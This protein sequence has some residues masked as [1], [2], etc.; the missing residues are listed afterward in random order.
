MNGKLVITG[1]IVDN[2][3]IISTLIDKG[4]Q[5]YAAMSEALFKKPGL[6]YIADGKRY[7]KGVTGEEMKA[8]TAGVTGFEINFNGHQ[9][10]IYAYV[11]P[12]LEFPL[13]LGNPWKAHNYVRTAPDE[14]RWYHGRLQ[15]WL[16]EWDVG[17]GPMPEWIMRILETEG[18]LLGDATGTGPGSRNKEP[19]ASLEEDD[20]KIFTV[21]FEDA[22]D[23]NKEETRQGCLP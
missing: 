18:E 13:I 8:R 6:P 4:C 7:V 14:G 11:V 2:I 16:P 15:E 9:S 10:L 20:L 22:V 5:Y 3:H 21:S 17:K 1:A 19:S 12:N 23:F